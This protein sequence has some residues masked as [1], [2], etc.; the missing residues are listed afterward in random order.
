MKKAL[1]E[2]DKKLRL[3]ER[4]QRE[5]FQVNTLNICML[6][7]CFLYLYSTNFFILFLFFLS[8]LFFLFNPFWDSTVVHFRDVDLQTRKLFM[9]RTSIT[10]GE[11]TNVKGL[12]SS[13][14]NICACIVSKQQSQ[15]N[16]FSSFKT[17]KV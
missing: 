2:F 4:K 3:F 6:L 10:T 16:F 17:E 15:N 11:K 8:F 12:S 5:W 13:T 14:W 7:N 1:Q 9:Q